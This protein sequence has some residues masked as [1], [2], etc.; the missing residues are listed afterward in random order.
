MS[1]L[2]SPLRPVVGRR[3]SPR[4]VART[5]LGVVVSLLAAT[6]KVV[7]EKLQ[8]VSVEPPPRPDPSVYEALAWDDLVAAGIAKNIRVTNAELQAEFESEV[9]E[10]LRAGGLLTRD[11][12]MKE[13]KKYGLRGARR[14]FQ[15]SKR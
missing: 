3:L 11:S 14:A 1:P 8:G 6:L 15:F 4:F 10:V 2:S 7:K 9:D 13:R 5:L 12:R